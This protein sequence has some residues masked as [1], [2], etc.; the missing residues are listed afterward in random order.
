M[1]SEYYAKY[2]KYKTKYLELKKIEVGG[3]PPRMSA[4]KSVQLVP[5][6]RESYNKIKMYAE[7]IINTRIR[8]KKTDM[9]RPAIYRQSS[10]MHK[11]DNEHSILACGSYFENLRERLILFLGDGDLAS[12]IILVTNCIINRSQKQCKQYLPNFV[13]PFDEHAPIYVD[14][15]TKGHVD[16]IIQLEIFLDKLK[17]IHPY[18]TRNIS[19][20]FNGVATSPNSWTII[21]HNPKN[22]DNIGVEINKDHMNY[23]YNTLVWDSDQ[24]RLR[25]EDDYNHKLG[26]YITDLHKCRDQLDQLDRVELEIN[27]MDED[28]INKDAINKKSSHKRARSN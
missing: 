8:P 11:Y 17:S 14:T 23:L 19:I 26:T 15:V 21:W 28:A 4:S 25:Q 1:N 3:T 20:H 13:I 9:P 5:L 10:G 12:A 7:Y 22:N 27:A 24:L 18:D 16:V 2:I 6:P